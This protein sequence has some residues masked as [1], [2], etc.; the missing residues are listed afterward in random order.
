MLAKDQ[1]AR[2]SNG[3]MGL[4]I[5]CCIIIKGILKVKIRIKALFYSILKNNQV[6]EM[7][8]EMR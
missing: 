6:K 8:P 1:V 2:F 5:L 3:V 7:L 4:V